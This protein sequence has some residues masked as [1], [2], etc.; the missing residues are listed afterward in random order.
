M[1]D[2]GTVRDANR[3]PNRRLGE[4]PMGQANATGTTRMETL[5]EATIRGHTVKLGQS[6]EMVQSRL[7]PDSL[8]D[9]TRRYGYSATARYIEPDATYV[10]TFGPPGKGVGSY[11]VLEIVRIKPQASGG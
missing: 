11:V 1:K 7:Q 4:E 10:V 9:S 2:A 8:L 6:A 3:E 5:T